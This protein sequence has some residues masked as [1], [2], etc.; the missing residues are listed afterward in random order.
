MLPAQTQLSKWQ[1]Q[2]VFPGIWAMA[3]VV[4]VAERSVLRDAVERH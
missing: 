4:R 1:H 2:P 3:A